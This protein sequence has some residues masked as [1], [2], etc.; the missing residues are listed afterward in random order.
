MLKKVK[1]K[2]IIQESMITKNAF[3]HFSIESF[4]AVFEEE[5]IVLKKSYTR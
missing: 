4:L 2:N 1:K 3:K 5:V